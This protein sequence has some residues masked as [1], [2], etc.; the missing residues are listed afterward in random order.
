MKFLAVCTIVLC[1][2]VPVALNNQ[3]ASIDSF[4][5]INRDRERKQDLFEICKKDLTCSLAPNIQNDAGTGQFTPHDT[6]IIC[7][8]R[9]LCGLNTFEHFCICS[10]SCETKIQTLGTCMCFFNPGGMTFLGCDICRLD[11]S[12]RTLT[13]AKEY[14][15]TYKTLGIDTGCL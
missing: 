7:S 8:G 13:L 11:R 15:K 9:A 5:S 14:I 1:S 6:P 4:D 12:I 10:V 2:C 3:D